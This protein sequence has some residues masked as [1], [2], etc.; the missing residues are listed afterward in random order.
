VLDQRNHPTR[1]EA[2]GPHHRPTP[3][4]LD[5]L[6]RAAADRRLHAPARARGDHVE[7]LDTVAGVDHDLDPV[8]AHALPCRPA[9]RAAAH[10]RSWHHR[11]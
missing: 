4:D 5:D 6:D 1:H 10:P 8:T 9:D 2:R 7:R 11:S 3:C